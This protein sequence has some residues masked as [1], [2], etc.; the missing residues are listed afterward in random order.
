[1]LKI[2]IINKL[3]QAFCLYEKDIEYIVQSGKVQI[4]DEHTGR[5]LHGRRYSDGL[6]EAIEINALSSWRL[7]EEFENGL[8]IEKQS[9]IRKEIWVN[10]SEAEIQPAFSP[11][12]EISKRLIGQL[13]T[14]KKVELMQ[15]KQSKLKIRKL[16]LGPFRST[17]NPI[18]I[19]NANFVANQIIIQS[20][21]Q[22]YLKFYLRKIWEN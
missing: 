9:P 1:M 4:V 17:L 8:N 11:S 14:F 7:M 16:I 18:G 2:H 20:Y 6:H 19:M 3:L 13:V 10:T 12:Y 22:S 5:V 15:K 21:L